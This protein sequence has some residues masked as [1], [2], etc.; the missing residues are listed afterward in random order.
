MQKRN[1][2]QP[3]HFN[4]QVTNLVTGLFTIRSDHGTCWIEWLWPKDKVEKKRK[5]REGNKLEVYF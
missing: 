3:L 4:D 2:G 1:R 5:R